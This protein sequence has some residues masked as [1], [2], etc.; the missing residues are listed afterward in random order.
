[1]GF[2]YIDGL[3]TP[4]N[5]ERFLSLADKVAGSRYDSANVFDIDDLLIDSPQ[6]QKCLE[7]VRSD[8]ASAQMLE[9]RYLGPEFDF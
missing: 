5:I 1:M 2:K 7:I 4:Q 6:M 9:E 3:A 8:P